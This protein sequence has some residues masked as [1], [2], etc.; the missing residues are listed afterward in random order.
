ML[1]DCF[2]PYWRGF[3]KTCAGET[4]DLFVNLARDA[5]YHREAGVGALLNTAHRNGNSHI[6]CQQP[7]KKLSTCGTVLPNDKLRLRRLDSELVGHRITANTANERQNR[8]KEP[9]SDSS[10]VTAIGLEN[11]PGHL[12]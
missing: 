10:R 5:P 8:R 1:K 12:L 3:E 11:Q 9:Q 6:L 4:G 7:K 2:V